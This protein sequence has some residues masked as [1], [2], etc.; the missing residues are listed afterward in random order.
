[1]SKIQ[2]TTLWN[3]VF[4]CCWLRPRRYWNHCRQL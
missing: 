3:L 1:M 2:G 4:A